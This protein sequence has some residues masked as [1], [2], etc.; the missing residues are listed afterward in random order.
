MTPGNRLRRARKLNGFTSRKTLHNHLVKLK[1][2]VSYARVG[3][4]ERDEDSPTINEINMFCSVLSMSSDWWLRSEKASS[5]VILKRLDGLPNKKRRFV[6]LM[7]NEI[8][9]GFD[10]Q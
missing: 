6:L 10:D 7:I 8:S 4:L 3:R 1:Y 2:N 5:A 9:Y